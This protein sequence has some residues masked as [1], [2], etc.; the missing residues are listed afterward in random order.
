VA[1][2]W[3]AVATADE[4]AAD[5]LTLSGATA[6]PPIALAPSASSPPSTV[7]TAIVTIDPANLRAAPTVDVQRQLAAALDSIG[8]SA[9]TPT[10]PPPGA[11][12][13]PATSAWPATTQP[14]AL[15]DAPPNAQPTNV[16]VRGQA[17]LASITYPWQ[18]RLPGWQIR[19][20]PGIDGAYG[21][22]LTDESIIDIYV[23]DGQSDQLLAHV[24]AHEIGHAVDVTL[25]DSA[26]RDRW[27][28]ARGF[29]AQ[30]WPDSRA[31]D[32]ATGAGDFAEC[33]AAWQVGTA[34]F[35][36]QLGGAPTGDHL[37]VVADL[38]AG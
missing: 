6:S 38:S 17:A 15:A 13:T 37:A 14:P 4:R 7:T 33:F 30:W 12:T 34:S 11:S 2:R 26:D 24:I 35:R 19:F 21:Y 28:A 22:T 27:Q 8:R 25:N 1:A 16:E 23:R 5:R 31:S 36:S 3:E 20:H 10:T 9:P 29:D 18:S 32:F